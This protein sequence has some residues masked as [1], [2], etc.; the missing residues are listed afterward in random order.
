MYT[1]GTYIVTWEDA[2]GFHCS[3]AFETEQS[4]RDFGNHLWKNPTIYVVEIS[5]RQFYKKRR[6]AV[7]IAR[8]ERSM[9]SC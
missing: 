1:A 3:P 9:K 4:A 5:R 8:A 2:S 7:T 6:N